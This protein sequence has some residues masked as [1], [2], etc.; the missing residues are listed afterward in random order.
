MLAFRS[1]L[2]TEWWS[3][4]V[5]QC[6]NIGALEC[7]VKQKRKARTGIDPKTL[8]KIKIPAKTVVAAILSMVETC[9]RLNIP[10]RGY[11]GSVLPGLTNFPI[12]QIAELTPVAWAARN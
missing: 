9:R 3:N 4:G 5:V 2:A 8:R 12:N 11:L 10:V 6:W 1:D 7:S